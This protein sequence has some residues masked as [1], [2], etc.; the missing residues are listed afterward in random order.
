ME[1]IREDYHCIITGLF[2]PWQT[3]HLIKPFDV[4][5]EFH[6]ETLKPMLSPRLLCHISNLL[7]LHKSREESII[8]RLQQ[9][10]SSALSLDDM[11]ILS[12]DESHNYFDDDIDNDDVSVSVFIDQAIRR[13]HTAMEL[14]FYVCEAVEGN[15]HNGY[16]DL[17]AHSISSGLQVIDLPRNV[18]QRSLDYVSHE[19]SI[20]NGSQ[21]MSGVTHSSTS[22][23]ES[24]IF[25]S[26]IASISSFIE[27]Y[28]FNTEQIAAFNIIVRHSICDDG[29]VNK[30]FLMGIFGEGGIGKS[31]LIRAI[32]EW[33]EQLNRSSELIVTASTGTTA[34]SV[35]GTTLHSAVGIPVE[36]GDVNRTS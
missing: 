6:F 25:L 19:F 20:A 24:T 9:Q 36:N 11:N 23:R 12:S 34:A 1:N 16:F 10:A 33:F 26:Q 30:Q 3:N 21:Q 13:I 17:F 32:R 14:D 2:F 28:H 15:S 4:S 18:V 27:Q 31:H 5:W 7:L 8:D 22:T 35:F 29:A